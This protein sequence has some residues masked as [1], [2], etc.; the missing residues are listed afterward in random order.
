[1][2]TI[3]LTRGAEAI[4]DDSDFIAHGHYKWHLSDSSG[5]AARR[6]WCSKRKKAGKKLYLHR[7]IMGAHDGQYVDHAN[8]NKLDNRKE[9]LRL[10]TQHQNQGNR[11]KLNRNNTTGFAGVTR[12]RL[13]FAAKCRNNYRNVHLG[14]F[15]TPEEASA[16]YKAYARKL[17]GEFASV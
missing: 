13:G 6:L 16:A 5:Y 3:Q 12:N 15:K 1:M 8:G 2:K 9:N 10:C 17:F 4:L 11:R 14:T 7:E